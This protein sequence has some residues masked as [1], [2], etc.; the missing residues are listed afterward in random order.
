MPALRHGKDFLK[1]KNVKFKEIDV[2]ND[3]NALR[4]MYEKTGQLGVPVIDI[5]GFLVIGFD[6]DMI[7][8]LLEKYSLLENNWHGG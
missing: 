5:N 3:A 2:A 4:E 1:K 6:R 8:N 7:E